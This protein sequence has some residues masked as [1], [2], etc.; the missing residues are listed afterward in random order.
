MKI[1]KQAYTTEFKELSV[2]RVKNGA[3]VNKMPKRKSKGCALLRRNLP[4][5]VEIEVQNCLN[6]LSIRSGSRAAMNI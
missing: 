2:K 5:K 4:P 1:P 3:R 6:R